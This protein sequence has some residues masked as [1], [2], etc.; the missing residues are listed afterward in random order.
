MTFFTALLAMTLSA[1]PLS[2]G[3]HERSLTVDETDREY[4]VYV[5]KVDEPPERGLPLVLA[6][7]G[8]GSRAAVMVVF[9]ELNDTADKHGFVVVYPNGTGRVE[10]AR[11]FNGGNCCGYAERRDVDDVKFTAA[12]LDDVANV[13][14]V[15]AKRV[16]ATG[17]SNGAI[18]C[19]RLADEMAGRIAAIAPVAGPMG[20][21]TCSPSRPVAVCHFHGT[22]DEFAAYDGG[23]GKRSLSRT[24]FYSVDHTIK[25]W[26]RANGCVEDPR[27]TELPNKIDD[28]TKVIRYEY[29]PTNDKR[30]AEVVHYKIEGGGHTWPGHPTR[31]RFLGKTTGNIDANEAMW[32]FFQRHRLP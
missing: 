17:M 1:D 23:P 24:N 14:A 9:S 5:P 29:A 8:G 30:G 6:F 19:Y 10:R 18:M 12:V 25:Q 21:E 31:F 4:L 13:V 32:E 16:Y 15:D 26:I 2:P 3:L 22:E 27:S 7:H 11:T 20:K 28:G